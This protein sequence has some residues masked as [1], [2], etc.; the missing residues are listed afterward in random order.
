M[1][2]KIIVSISFIFLVC[3]SIDGPPEVPKETGWEFERIFEKIDNSKQKRIFVYQV[4]NNEENPKQN[5]LIYSLLEKEVVG[6]KNVVLIDGQKL[7]KYAFHSPELSNQQL[8]NELRY[9]ADYLFRIE[10]KK[11]TYTFTLIK[12]NDGTILSQEKVPVSIIKENY[13]VLRVF[14][15]TDR[16]VKYSDANKVS[17]DN[18]LS[19][20]TYGFCDVSIPSGH[21]RGKIETPILD[22]EFLENQNRHVI[23]RET[24]I[25]EN[26]EFFEF[27]KKKIEN[28]ND[29]TAIIFIHGYN[30]NFSTAA[31]RTAQIAFDINFRGV[32]VFFSWPSKESWYKYPVDKETIETSKIN[33]RDFLREFYTRAELEKVYIVAHSMGTKAVADIYAFHKDS[34]PNFKEK[35]KEIILA[36]P[37]IDIDY[38]QSNIIPTFIQNGPNITVYS[39]KNDKALINSKR[40]N[41]HERVGESIRIFP[42]IE[43]IDASDVDTD[44]LGHSKFSESYQLLND[45]HYVLKGIRPQ[46]RDLKPIHNMNG[47]Y[48]KIIN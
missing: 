12:V 9:K 38:F 26:T 31:K 20:I 40:Y 2:L 47:E 37:D 7:K 32:P 27:L 6:R 42:L 5:S 48:W 36:S 3:Q 25:L 15:A 39:S 45:I 8:L 13:S 46:L 41:G 24:N 34:I 4:S 28:T 29:K 16:K 11:D 30:V 22:Y 23:L 18:E 17:F 44:F 43:T 10:D 14:F 35:T 19:T 21:K 33:L 1:K